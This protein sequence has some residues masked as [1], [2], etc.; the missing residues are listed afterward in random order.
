L[1]GTLP[2]EMSRLSKLRILFLQNYFLTGHLDNIFNHSTQLELAT[3]DI[4]NNRLTGPLSAA[5][6]LLPHLKVL[7]LSGML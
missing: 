6:F 3:V 2:A 4:S 5:I 1:V 7:S